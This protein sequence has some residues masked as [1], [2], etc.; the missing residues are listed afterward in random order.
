MIDRPTTLGLGIQTTGTQSAVRDI[1]PQSRTSLVERCLLFTAIVT[2]PLEK[3]VPTVAGM[4]LSFLIFAVLAAYIIVNRPRALGKIWYHPVFIAAYAF[5]GVSALLE[6]SSPLSR[7]EET[8][9]FAQMIGGVVCVAALCR[10]RSGL[11][12]GLYGYIGAALW[13]STVLYLTSYGMLKE[14]GETNSFQEASNLRGH[15]DTGITAN[16]NALA[17]VC[18]QGVIVAFALSLSDRLKHLRI[19]LLGLGV[20]CLVAAFLPMS[21][22]AAVISFVSIAAILYAHGVKQ[23]KA[24]IFAAIVGMGIYVLV[25]DAVWSRMSFS[26]EVRGNGKMEARAR[27]YTTALNHLP[28]YVIGG[29]GAGNYY[30][31]WGLQKGLF[32]RATGN[33]LGAHN[34]LLQITIFWGVLG[35]FM[36]LWFVWLVYR[37]IPLRCGR[38]ELSLALLGIMVSLA[39]LIL[40]SHS[41]YDKW[42]AFGIGMVLGARQW[43]WPTGVVSGVDVNQG[44]SQHRV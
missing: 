35:L 42:F 44:L 16:I 2:L 1:V 43:I 33:V 37:S 38:D 31:R 24:L 7:Y 27:V 22:G 20:F 14:V 10:D 30:A 8:I 5:V 23:G 12:V 41:F 11:A 32:S 26:T 25:P 6:F 29:V 19:P 17:F 21:R 28:E 9:R 15:L 13:V 40:D 39:M 34:V 36:Y 3:H 4:S 18:T